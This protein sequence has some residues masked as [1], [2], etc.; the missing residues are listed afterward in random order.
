MTGCSTPKACRT[1]DYMNSTDALRWITD[2]LESN[3][4]P[5]LICGGLAAIAYGATRPLYD[6]DLYV[7]EQDFK[8]VCDFGREQITFG[9]QRFID[10]HWNV[11][12]VQFIYS[13]QKIEVGSSQNIQIFDTSEQRWDRQVPDFNRYENIRVLGTT[14]RVMGKQSLI[15]YK[16]KLNR[17]VDRL[18]I[19]QIT[20]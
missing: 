19:E 14:V 3:N 17:Q 6:I 7:P 1:R 4:I 16:R 20:E 10:N 13:Q 12:Y 18:D 5:Y 11:E 2:F 8:R 15:D 9:P